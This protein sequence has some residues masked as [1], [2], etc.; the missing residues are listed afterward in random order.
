[1]SAVA[2]SPEWTA[3]CKGVK[4]C[5]S[6]IIGQRNIANMLTLTSEGII[7]A[8]T[9]LAKPAEMTVKTFSKMTACVCGSG[10][11]SV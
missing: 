9:Y 10:A 2:M 3:C 6:S 4:A 11:A 1:M 8:V 5:L 7:Q